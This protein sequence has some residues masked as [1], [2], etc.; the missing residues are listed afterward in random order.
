MPFIYSERTGRYRDLT[1]GKFVPT[2]QVRQAVDVVIQAT[3]DQLV[4]LTKGLQAG[5]VPL[6]VWQTT[7]AQEIKGLHLATAAAAQG[8]WAQLSAADLGWTG[9]RIRTQYEYL[10]TFAEDIV[11]GKQKMDGTLGVRASLY[12]DAARGTN[13]EMERRMARLGGLTEEINRLGP[14]DHCSGGT[15]CLDETAK[16][17]VAI[18]TLVAVGAR[19][20]Q[21][22]C[23]CHLDYRAA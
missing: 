14:A 21:S 11:S 6:D 12:A 23:R 17:W 18:G 3:G 9:Q 8:G 13:R 20:C 22:R 4:Q 5:A 16:G 2:Q 19:Q 10:R 7:V 15:S 1:S